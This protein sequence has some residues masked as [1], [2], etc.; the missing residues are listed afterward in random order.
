MKR[1][2]YG[3][4]APMK[5]HNLYVYLLNPIGILLRGALAALVLLVALKVFT[6]PPEY[7]SYVAFDG[8][9]ESTSLWILF[10]LRAL[11]FLLAIWAEVLL[12]KRRVL[13]VLILIADY[14][15]NVVSAFMT[16]YNE[17]TN[18]NILALALIALISALV[19]LYYWRRRRIL[20]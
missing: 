19:C 11:A 20:R 6:M 12:A 9:S 15:M 16:A 5:F 7:A 8:V 14:V 13:G 3:Q 17:P 2:V 1:Y 4:D 10:G 18:E